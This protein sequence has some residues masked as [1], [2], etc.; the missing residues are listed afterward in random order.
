MMMRTIVRRIGRLPLIGLALL[1]TT[2]GC[3]Q[4]TGAAL[5][6]TQIAQVAQPTFTP[7][8]QKPCSHR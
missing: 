8:R 6:A 7:H 5:E 3:F 2:A 1:L 4:P